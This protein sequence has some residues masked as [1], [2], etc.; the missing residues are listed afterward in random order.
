MA[1]ASDA[2]YA[3]VKHWIQT[4]Q[5]PP[6]ALIDEADA[7][8]RLAVSRTPVR[9]AL[10]RLQSEG[11]VEIGRGKGIRVRGFT[12]ADM[13][14]IYQVIS[15][16]EVAAVALIADRRPAPAEFSALAEAVGELQRALSAGDVDGW[17]EADERFHRELMRLSG[18][19]RLHVVGCDFRDLSRRA[20][21]VALRL[22]GDAYRARSTASHAALLRALRKGTAANLADLHLRQRR[23]GEDALI[24][25]VE[26]F[27]LTSL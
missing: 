23:R 26:R 3:A 2:A 7:A 17:G 20:H 27:N 11:Y 14:H 25:V 6:G 5:I 21:L 9:E 24:S 19:P 10:L 13:R 12:P 15:G 4:A 16:L 1:R 8:R 18:N 22:Q